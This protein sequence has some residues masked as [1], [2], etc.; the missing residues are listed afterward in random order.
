MPDK[1]SQIFDLSWRSWPELDSV[2][3][4]QD[5]WTTASILDKTVETIEYLDSI[6][7]NIV[8]VPVL[9]SPPSPESNVVVHSN[10]SLIP[11]RLWETTLNW[12]KGFSFSKGVVLEIVLLPRKV[13]MMGKTF[14]SSFVQDCSLSL[15][16]RWTIRE[17]RW[18]SNS[19]L[20]Y[21]LLTDVL[22]NPSST[23]WFAGLYNQWDG[24]PNWTAKIQPYGP[25]KSITDH[26]RRE[27]SC[28]SPERGVHV[29][30]MFPFSVSIVFLNVR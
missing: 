29:I 14:W 15:A 1:R 25:Q 6:F 11:G 20:T 16:E 28:S 7:L 13:N 26:R 21:S 3:N 24:D 9:S 5:E 4:K 8:A 23:F 2:P 19:V 30:I 22:G 12:G 18:Q 17:I 10:E 27:R